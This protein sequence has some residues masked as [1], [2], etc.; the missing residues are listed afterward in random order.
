MQRHRY[1]VTG[2]AGFIG[3]NLVEQLLDQGQQVVAIDNFI[4]GKQENIDPFLDDIEFIEGDI[5]DFELCQ[6]LTRNVDFVL[7]QAALGSVPRSIDD[8]LTTNDH[9]TNGTLNVLRAAVL[10]QVRRVV[11]ASSSSAYGDTAVLPKVETMTPKPLSPYAVS[12]LTGEHYIAAFHRSYGLGA[13]ALR[14][15]NVFGPRQDPESMYAAVI[16]KFVAAIRRGDPPLIFGD[17]EQSRDFTFI[18][19]VV[20]ANLLACQAP[21][22]ADGQVFNIGAGGR[23]T[24][25]E[26]TRR[27]IA[28]LGKEGEIEIQHGDP[29][30]GD[31]R[32]SQ[33]DITRA[34]ETLGYDPKVDVAQGLERTVNWYLEHD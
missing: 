2:A 34:R 4:T 12:K 15:F 1:L 32:H 30:P 14:Y 28:L 29:R 3:S 22:E 26:L 16:P 7:H 23:I 25:N 9:N 6:K 33:A 8:P 24:I 19:N 11:Y 17:G 31:V 10:S 18:E 5:R 27:L 13:V 20:Q 21:P